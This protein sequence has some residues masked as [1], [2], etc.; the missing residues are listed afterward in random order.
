MKPCLNHSTLA[1]ADV[2]TF[3]EASAS[4]GFKGVEL[5]I[6]KLR[7]Y[8]A[9]NNSWARLR[10]LLHERQLESVCFNSFEDF[11]SVPVTDLEPVLQ[12]AKEFSV[13][14]KNTD[15]NLFVACPSSTPREMTKEAAL[16]V[17]ADRLERIAKVAAESSLKVGFEFVYGRSAAKLEDAI[18]VVST[19]KS[20]NVGLVVDT[21]HYYIGRSTLDEFK[22]FPLERLWVVHFNDAEPGPLETL[23]DERRLLPG[24][25]V[26]KLHEF[27]TWLKNRGWNGWF[28]VEM[29]RPEY[30]KQEPHGLA[31]EVM[32]SL[33]PYL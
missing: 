14:C 16:K 8:F 17:T 4:A 3:L 31:K 9:L 29:F 6:E 19:V 2:E 1:Q 11:G 22:D 27:A 25:G 15:C 32:K 33:K 12:R 23:T 13:I 7:P 10:E 26:I 21:F 24:S 5:R 28:S 18:K 20:E 30:W